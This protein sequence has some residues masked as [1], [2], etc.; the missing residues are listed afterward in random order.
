CI[1]VTWS[2][3]APAL[4]LLCYY[5]AARFWVDWILAASVHI[6]FGPLI[7]AGLLGVWLAECSSNFGGLGLI[8]LLSSDSRMLL[9]NYS[10]PPP[11]H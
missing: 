11:G 2:G 3:F 10:L 7:A 6:Q 1:S 5:A 9:S 4:G 8:V